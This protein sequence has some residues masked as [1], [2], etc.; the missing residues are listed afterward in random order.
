MKKLILALAISFIASVVF[1][2]VIYAEMAKEGT[3]SAT[4]VYSGSS[5][6]IPIDEDALVIPYQNTGVNVSDTGKGP[7]HNMSLVN[8]GIIYFEKGVGKAL[9]YI[10]L[11]DPEGDKVVIEIR[12]DNSKFPPAVSNG[13][14][15]LIYGTGKFAGIEGTMEYKRWNVR[16][17][18]K[19]TYQ[20]VAKVKYSWK[21]PETKE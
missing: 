6:M 15:E 16:P 10:T 13:T 2:P 5:N 7:L 4:C 9:G 20:A 14:G 17:A 12:E 8:A 3:D 19:D 21:I 11:T 1:T 18:T